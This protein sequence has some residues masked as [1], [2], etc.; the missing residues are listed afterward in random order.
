MVERYKRGGMDDVSKRSW[1]EYERTLNLVLRHK[2]T[3][4]TEVAAAPIKTMTTLGVEK[5]YKALKK[6]SRVKVRLRQANVCIIRMGRAWDYVFKRYPNMFPV[7]AVNPFRAVELTHSKGTTKPASR[8]EAYAL[9]RALDAVAEPHLP[10]C[11]SRVSNGTSGQRTCSLDISRGAT[12]DLL[13]GRTL[14][15]FCTTRPARSCGSR[16]SLR[17]ASRCSQN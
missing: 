9:H 11:R 2:T 8:G 5:I 12:I 1:C 3:I 4:G 7:R 14:S 6:G 10:S 15:A 13:S 17:M 16:L